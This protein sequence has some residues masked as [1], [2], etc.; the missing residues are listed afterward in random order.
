MK[1]II[2]DGYNVIYK[3]PELAI[4]LDESLSAAR[5]ALA[6]H[7]SNWGRK[8]LYQQIHIVFDGQDSATRGYSQTALHGIECSFTRTKEEADDRILSMIRKSK[9]PFNITVISAD[10]RVSNSCRTHGV[11][12][13]PPSFLEQTTK[14]TNRKN[15]GITKRIN[16]KQNK[17]IIDYYAAHLKGKGKI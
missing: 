12:V 14:K 9:E 11:S 3:I 13:K 10:N 15:L 4:K 2:L 6:M 7:M 5:T 17:E 8:Y 1:T 16:Y